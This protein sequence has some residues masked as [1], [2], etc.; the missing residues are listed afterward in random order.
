MA[1]LTLL[2]VDNKLWND[3][4]SRVTSGL[5]AMQVRGNWGTTVANAW[6]AL[7][8][9]KFAA[10]FESQPVIG[11]TEATLNA[12]KQVL[13]WA[14]NPS[15]GNLDLAW[16]PAQ[17]DLHLA[18]SGSGNPWAIIQANAAVPIMRPVSSGYTI[19]KTLTPVDSSHSGG[20][21]QGD[22]VRVHLK[23]DAQSDMTWV[24]VDDPIPAGASHLGTGLQRDSQIATS[25][26]QTSNALLMESRGGLTAAFD[27]DLFWPDFVERPFDAYRAYYQY[28]PKGSFEVEY[29]I[30]LNQAGQFQMPATRVEALYEPEM[31]GEIPNARFDVAP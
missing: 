6:G 8:T 24:V 17:S 10:T 7:A 15:G 11:E 18:Q 4:V 25:G 12:M 19:A 28:I 31:F 30:R 16:P 1:R 27:S 2:L 21:R 9:E 14:K 3:D 29:T 13:D 22:L 5:I 20:W 23:I 26:E